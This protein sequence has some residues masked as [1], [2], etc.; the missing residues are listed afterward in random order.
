MVNIFENYNLSSYNTFGVDSNAKFFTTINNYKCFCQL[1]KETSY[2]NAPKLVLGGGSNLIFSSKIYNGFVISNK[3]RGINVLS[4]TKNEIILKVGGGEN[5]HGLVCYTLE[6]GW[7]GLENLSLIPGSVG[8][9]P[10][11]NIGAY[12][13]ELKDVFESLEAWDLQTGEIRI[14]TKEECQFGYRNSIFKQQLRGQYFI[15]SV[16]FKLNQTKALNTNYGAIE[17][18]LNAQKITQARAKDVSKTIIK[19]RESKLPNP[20]KI[21]N[22]GSFFKNPIINEKQFLAL[23][24]K[25]ADLK[26]YELANKEYK[27]PAAW[28]IEQCGLKG[29]QLGNVGVSENHALILINCGKAKGEEVVTLAKK[30]QNDVFNKF[31]ISLEAEANIV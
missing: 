8:A 5:W 23:K 25:F 29:I 31:A 1:I 27:I 7:R 21:G 22:V 11:Q 4:E 10:I 26:F 14:F 15:A 9:A 12:G 3:V 17:A 2:K 13:I 24:E 6:N 20:S 19:I 28:L 30:I 16:I 18:E